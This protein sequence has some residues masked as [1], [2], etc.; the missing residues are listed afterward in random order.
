MTSNRDSL[1]P[2]ENEPRSGSVGEVT[3]AEA[4]LPD[5]ALVGEATLQDAKLKT[6]EL[7]R[8]L[9]YWL[10]T[11]P[12]QIW[13]VGAI[14][15]FGTAGFTGTALLLKSPKSPQCSRVFWPIA[16]ASMRLYCAQ[17]EA[18][19]RT[20]DSLLKAIAL[21][22]VLP[23]DH[24]L[25]HE[26]D[27]HVEEWAVEILDL[28]EEEFQAG[29][30]DN[31]IAIARKIPPSVSAHQ[32]VEE[33]IQKWQAV[34]DEGKGIYSEVEEQL[35]ETNWNQAF[36]VA[37][38]LLNLNNRYWA[39]QKYDE[40]VAQIQLAQEES[41]KLDAAYTILRQGGMDNWLKAAAEAQ[42]VPS[43]SYAHREAQKLIDEAKEKI[44]G[45]LEDQF[46]RRNWSA[47]LDAANRVPSNLSLDDKISDWK[48]LASA[49]TSADLGT[50]GDLQE[51]I[52]TAQKIPPGSDL[53]DRAQEM[54][55][56]WR[57]E[58]EDVQN[59][60]KARDLAQSGTPDGLQAAIAQADLVPSNHPRYDE[61]RREIRGWTRQIETIEDQPIL[62]R[63]RAIA[64]SGSAGDLQSA[65][66]EASAIRPNRALYGEA[67][68]SIQKWRATIQRQEDQPILDQAIALANA[69][70][71]EAAISAANQIGRGR[72]LYGEA[73]TKVQN[74][75]QEISAKRIL[76]DANLL[77]QSR[78]PESLAS[79]MR[80]LRK[81]PSY[82]SADSERDRL[83]DR[84]G[85]QLLS[86]AQDRANSASLDE[87]IQ[88][89]QMV[90][91]ASAAYS[92]ARSQISEWRQMLRPETNPAPSSLPDAS[93][94]VPV[95]GHS[96][97]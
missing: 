73:Q 32:L 89:A 82:T 57:K 54:V 62:D 66:T 68:A 64:Q 50:P 28:A 90:P 25:S 72:A 43:S 45:Y 9:S 15:V 81:I 74:W 1:I 97:P 18:E 70:D 60:D 96:T 5:S 58:I 30:L 69:D 59:I 55:A 51:A 33:R 94:G 26:I 16:S 79:A 23:K 20:V 8:V 36:R 77:A 19:T 93:G 63:A 10:R 21:V 13:A 39:T 87:A 67:S 52:T 27:R 11:V 22:Q 47:F 24:P 53:Y 3:V 17:L 44:L 78:S 6:V 7:R 48:T 56:T 84:W 46:N 83:M 14:A 49:G 37:V 29:K 65:I 2:P 95:Y 86:L 85:F 76:N 61:A 80:L 41:R 91:R 4:A 35:R 75:R 38:K 31:A 88:V 42:K 12:W 34:W 71:Y 40:T 92:A